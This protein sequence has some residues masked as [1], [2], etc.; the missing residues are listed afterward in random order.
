MKLIQFPI[1][2]KN[3]KLSEMGINGEFENTVALINATAVVSIYPS[4]DEDTDEPICILDLINGEGF[5]IY[6]TYNDLTA[7][8]RKH[9]E[10]VLTKTKN[11]V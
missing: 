9:C 5:S 2:T 3:R 8:M 4:T 1:R 7:V 6:M 10:I 11:P